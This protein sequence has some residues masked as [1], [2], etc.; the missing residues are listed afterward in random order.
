VPPFR[1]AQ[2]DWAPLLTSCYHKALDLAA[3]DYDQ[4]VDLLSTKS[5]WES[6][7][8]TVTRYAA[9]IR[10]PDTAG[11][12]GSA[13]SN[14]GHAAAENN[15]KPLTV[16]IPLLGAGARGACVSEAAAAGAAA[17]TAW[18]D[19]KPNMYSGAPLGEEPSTVPVAGSSM[20]HRP[21][22]IRFGC[23]DPFVTKL[24]ETSFQEQGWKSS[25]SR[26]QSTNKR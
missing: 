4:P 15:S 23:T 6:I 25:K 21:L 5:T 17:V 8:S 1:S 11:A 7:K 13:S 14:G 19:S 22:S 12:E 20:Q 26:E 18:A 3:T 10:V 16:A 24:L 2:A 9:A